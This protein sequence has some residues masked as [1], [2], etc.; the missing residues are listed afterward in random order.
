[1]EVRQPEL[2]IQQKVI[3]TISLDLLYGICNF[4][5][6]HS[7]ERWGAE[8]SMKDWLKDKLNEAW[9]HASGF[10]ES[11]GEPLLWSFA[12]ATFS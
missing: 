6:A 3:R 4:T 1:M 10:Q 8:N 5:C 11:T 12:T 2:D 7:E 9:V